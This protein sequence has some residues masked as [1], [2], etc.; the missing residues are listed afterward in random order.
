MFQLGCSV[1]VVSPLSIVTYCRSSKAELQRRLWPR[2]PTKIERCLAR[3]HFRSLAH[4]TL[5][6]S[7][8]MVLLLALSCQEEH[9]A[10]E[11]RS[12]SPF[13]S[14]MLCSCLSKAP[15]QYGER[16]WN[17]CTS[18]NETKKVLLGWLQEHYIAGGVL[19]MWSGDLLAVTCASKPSAVKCRLMRSS[20]SC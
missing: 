5:R 2:T 10:I 8:H 13:R 17:C 18:K 6:T 19:I 15:T 1:D 12:K 4:G 3:P 11:V 14:R 20:F 7:P 16:Q 9:P